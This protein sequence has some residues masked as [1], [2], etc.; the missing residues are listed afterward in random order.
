MKVS[1]SN[2]L[3]VPNLLSLNI[4]RTSFF[5]FGLEVIWE[6]DSTLLGFKNVFIQYSP[7]LEGEPKSFSSLYNLAFFTLSSLL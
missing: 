6:G 7:N 3:R 4:L 5:S 1:C 2:G